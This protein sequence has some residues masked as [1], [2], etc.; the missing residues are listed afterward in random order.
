MP[1][2]GWDTHSSQSFQFS[3]IS[4]FCCMFQLLLCISLPFILGTDEAYNR[5]SSLHAILYLSIYYFRFIPPLTP[6]SHPLPAS[7]QSTG[8]AYNIHSA[9]ANWRINRSLINLGNNT[10]PTTFHSLRSWRT[11]QFV[12]TLIQQPPYTYHSLTSFESRFLD[13]PLLLL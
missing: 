3:S 13:M 2:S 4:F 7:S 5:V 10:F 1:C 6:T 9:A 11:L 12:Q 8:I